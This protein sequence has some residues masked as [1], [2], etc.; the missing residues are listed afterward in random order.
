MNSEETYI[1]GENFDFNFFY[2]KANIGTPFIGKMF[3][4]FSLFEPNLAGIIINGFCRILFSF[5]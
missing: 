4:S 2:L 1:K 5:I 3:L